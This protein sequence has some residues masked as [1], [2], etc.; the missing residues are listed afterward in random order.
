MIWKSMCKRQWDWEESKNEWEGGESENE[1]SARA[2]VKK[3][4]KKLLVWAY[5]V[6]RKLNGLSI[7]TNILMSECIGVS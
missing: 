2:K 3:M 4:P 1:G 7:G 6:G 5:G